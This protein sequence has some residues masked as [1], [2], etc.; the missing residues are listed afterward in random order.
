MATTPSGKK[1]ALEVNIPHHFTFV[2]FGSWT[3]GQQRL[4]D[5][6]LDSLPVL[7]NF[8]KM[9]SP[10]QKKLVYDTTVVENS[11]TTGV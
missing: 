2:S 11:Q 4:F 10:F 9:F 5:H 3:N 6:C 8:D 7:D 1:T